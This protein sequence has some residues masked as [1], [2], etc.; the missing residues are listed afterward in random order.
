MKG[1]ENIIYVLIIVGIM[2][3][4]QSGKIIKGGWDILD[5]KIWSVEFSDLNIFQKIIAIFC[6]PLVIIDVIFISKFY[7]NQKTYKRLK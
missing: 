4:S 3:L 6:F 7:K 2:L 1:I 5:K